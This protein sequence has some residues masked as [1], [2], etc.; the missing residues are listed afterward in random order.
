MFVIYNQLVHI[1]VS[2]DKGS[3]DNACNL[4]TDSYESH[5]TPENSINNVTSAQ[6]WRRNGWHVPNIKHNLGDLQPTCP[7]TNCR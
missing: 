7:Y 1:L 6:N 3:K 2:D 4:G 5:N